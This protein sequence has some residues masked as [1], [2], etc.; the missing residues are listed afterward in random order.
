MTILGEQLSFAPLVKMI[1]AQDMCGAIGRDN[2]IPWHLSEDLQH[3]QQVTDG[4]IVIMG[5]NTWLSLPE[6]SRPLPGRRNIVLTNNPQS[7]DYTGATPLSSLTAALET[8]DFEDTVWIIGGAALYQ[9]GLP[10]A[11]ELYV[12]EVQLHV[13]NADTFA[14][15]ISDTEYEVAEK[16]PWLTSRNDIEYRFVRYARS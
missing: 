14:P 16:S 11:D 13:E 6:N 7:F 5:K 3:F 15:N 8:A 10:I 1:W 2:T 4:G 12:T 9:A